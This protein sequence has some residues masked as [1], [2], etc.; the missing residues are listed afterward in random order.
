M[1]PNDTMHEA[2]DAAVLNQAA[3]ESLEGA[4]QPTH[5]QRAATDLEVAYYDN[6]RQVFAL[7]PNDSTVVLIR[8]ERNTRPTPA[9]GDKSLKELAAD[10][11]EMGFNQVPAL[12][13]LDAETGAADL[14]DGFRRA[15]AVQ[16][17]NKA[18]P[19]KPATLQVL[20]VAEE[21]PYAEVIRR[22]LGANTQR[23]DLNLLDRTNALVLLM[24][25]A[26]GDLTL[27]DAA[28][29]MNMSKGAASVY[30]RFDL[31]PAIAKKALANGKLTYSAAEKLMGLLP[32]REALLADETGEVLAKAQER[33]KKM[34]EKELAS[35]DKVSTGSVDQ[36]TRNVA[37]ASGKKRANT[38]QRTSKAVLRDIDAYV[39]TLEEGSEQYAAPWLLDHVKTYINGK[40]KLAQL[41]E[42]IEELVGTSAAE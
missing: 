17:W 38:R 32:S 13:T 30:V 22:S 20:I 35:G 36:A 9:I 40:M 28:K 7:D 1:T 34:L 12:A 16:T 37:D 6:P 8:P 5:A 14:Y 23:L 31:F 27:A 24:S 42:K 29:V 15:R 33:I 4:E 25:E 19:D 2:A 10:I 18:N 21:L 39:K 11:G 26:G 3:L 41:V